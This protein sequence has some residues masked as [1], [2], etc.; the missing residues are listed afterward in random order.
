MSALETLGPCSSSR[1]SGETYLRSEAPRL[2]TLE[3]C[4]WFRERMERGTGC[5]SGE[6]REPY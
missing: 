6:R 5:K 2:L 1:S 4:F 3:A